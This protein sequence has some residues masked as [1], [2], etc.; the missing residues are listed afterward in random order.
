MRD[1]EMM[2]EESMESAHGGSNL[3]ARRE[4]IK[5]L[6]QFLNQSEARLVAPKEE[7]APEMEQAEDEEMSPEELDAL[8]SMG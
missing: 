7:P 1:M 5:L 8:S 4:A 6:K 2:Q 3:A